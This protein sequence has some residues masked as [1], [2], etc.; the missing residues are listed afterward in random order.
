[1]ADFQDENGLGELPEDLR[2]Q[3]L[4]QFVPTNSPNF[5]INPAPSP[6][7][8]SAPQKYPQSVQ[9]VFPTIPINALDF[10]FTASPLFSDTFVD[11][12]IEAVAGYVFVVKKIEWEMTPRVID[13][14]TGEF[15][16]P[17]LVI[18][19]NASA[20]QNFKDVTNG[21][22]SNDPAVV[23]DIGSLDLNVIVPELGKFNAR[24]ITGVALDP[25]PIMKIRVSGYA[26]LSRQLPANFEI[27]SV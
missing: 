20:I 3:Y 11:M 15:Y 22:A 26:L 4:E 25:P 18:S 19:V 1:M 9:S 10:L 2:A 24:F 16:Q 13:I 14:L 5:S 12:T 8:S 27:G 17:Q 6:E 21:F 7:L 23:D